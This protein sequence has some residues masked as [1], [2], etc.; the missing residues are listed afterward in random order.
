[1]EVYQCIGNCLIPL[2]PWNKSAQKCVLEKLK[3]C[4]REKAKYYVKYLSKFCALWQV[5]KI[6][7]SFWSVCVCLQCSCKNLNAMAYTGGVVLGS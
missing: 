6:F 4:V 5:H 1:M 2:D 7:S 3:V